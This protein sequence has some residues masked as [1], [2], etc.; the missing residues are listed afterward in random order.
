LK[1]EAAERRSSWATRPATG[2]VLAGS[3]RPPFQFDQF[4]KTALDYSALD[5]QA[6]RA[7]PEAG[8]M[9]LSSGCREPGVH[10]DL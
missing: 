6:V 5:D 1:G 2:T 7:D 3:R 10:F 9:D 8:L 4:E